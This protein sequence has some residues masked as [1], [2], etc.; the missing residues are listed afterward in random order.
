MSIDYKQLQMLVKEA[1]FTG[2][3][4][5]EPSYP[6]DIPHRMPSA[7]TWDKQQD[8]G[9]PE[10]NDLYA[11]AVRARAGVEDLI[12]ALDD[13]S[14]DS[15]YEYAFKASAC[16]RKVL[17]SLEESGAHPMPDERVV[18][19]PP[20]MQKYGGYVPYGGTLA[21][22]ANGAADGMIA[23][24]DAERVMT[25][26]Q[27]QGGSALKNG[28]GLINTPAELGDLLLA[29]AEM[30]KNNDAVNDDLMK[31]VTAGLQRYYQQQ[32]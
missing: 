10:A 20:Q 23:E 9:D 8:M 30:I 27:K 24:D 26:L 21:Y 1:M 19:P 2:G 16:M 22:G 31:T 25:V 11:I 4:I 12:E 28:L 17:N 18:T 15:A 5:N 29:V 7:D 3:G 32:G 13:P 6:E 14:F